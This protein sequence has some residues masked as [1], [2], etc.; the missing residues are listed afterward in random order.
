M[1]DCSTPGAVDAARRLREAGHAVLTCYADDENACAALRGERCPLDW[2]AIDIALLVRSTATTTRLPHEEG[3]VC[4]AA[5]NVPLV[6]AGASD[7][8]PYGAWAVTDE[9]SDVETTLKTVMA[10]PL[11][12]QTITATA[13]LRAALTRAGVDP[14]GSWA[15]VYRRNGG[16]VA[17][18][19]LGANV[20]AETAT[21]MAA[22]R[23]AG[24]LRAADPWSTAIDVR[25]A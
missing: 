20:P 8:H 12:S 16:L 4:A 7:G 19:V 9:G 14:G 17:E 11:P 22:V 13:A 18:I 15:P 10:T 2:Q 21:E 24:A 25:V 5:R 3:V 23:I 6:V 1:P